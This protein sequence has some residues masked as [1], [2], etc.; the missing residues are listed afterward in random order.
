ME[1]QVTE[2]DLD[3]TVLRAAR[4][5]NGALT[6]RYL[7]NVESELSGKPMSREDVACMALDTA[8][9]GSYI[10]QIVRICGGRG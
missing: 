2:S 10:R 7:V 3:W 4:F 8:E 1:K 5:T 6:G 9:R